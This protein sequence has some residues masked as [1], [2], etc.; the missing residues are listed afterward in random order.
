M[1]SG[2]THTGVSRDNLYSVNRSYRSIRQMHRHHSSERKKWKGWYLV[3]TSLYNPPVFSRP[4]DRQDF[5]AE[6][7]LS[8]CARQGLNHIICGDF[9]AHSIT[10]DSA[11][12]VVESE[13]GAE[14]E[15]LLRENFATGDSTLRHSTTRTWAVSS[16]VLTGGAGVGT[17]TYART[18]SFWRALF[19]CSLSCFLCGPVGFESDLQFSA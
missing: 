6:Y 11:E 15:G 18:F 1:W 10:W 3:V 8:A 13:E 7:T 16:T 2:D 19:F 4:R 9:N 12:D 5:S 17:S 14:I